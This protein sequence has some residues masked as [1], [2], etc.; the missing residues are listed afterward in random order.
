MNLN[1]AFRNKK[2][3]ITGHTGFKGSWMCMCLEMLGAEVKGYALKPEK[4]SLYE[5]IKKNLSISSVYADIRNSEKLKKEILEFQPDFIFHMAAQALVRKSY[6]NPVETYETNVLGTVNLLDALRSLKKKCSCVIV[7]TDKVYENHESNAA[8]KESDKLGGHDPYSASKSAAEIITE[9][10][11]LS[12]FNPDDYS[13]HKKS[14]ASARAGNVIGGGDYATDRI[15]PDIFRALSKRQVIK[16]RNPAAVRPWQH[17]LEPLHGYL[18]LAAAMNKDAQKF[19]ESF[20]FGPMISDTCTVEQLVKMAIE[21]WGSGT[22]KVTRE[23]NAPHEAGQLRLDIS[24]AKKML[25]WQPHWNSK[26][27]IDKTISWYKKS[28][29]KNFD[30]VYL[31]TKDISEY[32]GI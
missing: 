6:M 28:T 5:K 14:I 10:Y 11:R 16:V 27:A 1:S 4:N 26:T 30:F 7:T 8:Y 13:K 20:N 12:F 25:S 23:K 24:K 22:Y 31:C 32:F 2:V 3:F 18:T 17:V 19:A 9:S 15:L 29:S 21:S